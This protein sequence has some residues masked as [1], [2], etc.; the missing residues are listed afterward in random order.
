MD[1]PRRRRVVPS[2]RL[3]SLLGW[4][5][6]VCF[7]TAPLVAQSP[8]IN[9]IHYENTG[10]DTG[11]AIEVA[12]VAGTDLLGWR[13]VLYNGSLVSTGFV[14]HEVALSGV[15]PDL[16]DGLGV[17]SFPI[18]ANPG[19]QDGP[20]DGV[21]LVAPSGT[22]VELL[23][24]EGTFTGADGP[25]EDLVSTDIGVSQG[26]STE[27]GFSL[28]LIGTGSED[29]DFA[30]AANVAASFGSPNPGQTFACSP[31]V[32]DS[33][34]LDGS[35]SVYDGCEIAVGPDVDV[36]GATTLAT[37]FASITG[38]FS[39]A[40]GARFRVRT[41]FGASITINEILADPVDDANGDFDVDTTDDE[42][43]ELVNDGTVFLDLTGWTL[44]DSTTVRHTFATMPLLAPGCAV[45]VFG[46]GSPNG[47]FGGAQVVV[48]S[49]GTLSLTN[50]GDSLTLE[51]PSGVLGASASFGAEADLEQSLT[52]SPDVDGTT[53]VLHGGAAGSVGPFSPGTRVDGTPHC[54]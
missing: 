51:S 24:Y 6:V 39:V 32:I 1:G 49:N 42:F 36:T 52:R 54:P 53:L 11:E 5:P 7:A 41:I 27:A 19:I 25:A 18:P 8:F 26:T 17:L 45:V 14:Y 13:L 2:H 21:A 38:P 37:P 47:S 29:L 44:A 30:W 20:S 33:V 12:A 34:E 43:V 9:E 35:P 48:A 40:T 31:L 23:S 46:G 16:Q 3:W 15:V 4:A 28:A 10:T 22:V 50:G